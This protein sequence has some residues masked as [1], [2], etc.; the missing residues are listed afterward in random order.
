MNN[1]EIISDV[2]ILNKMPNEDIENYL[3]NKYKNIIRWAVIDVTDDNFKI[4]I[5]YENGLNK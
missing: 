5:T 4:S 3:N 2:I 1:K